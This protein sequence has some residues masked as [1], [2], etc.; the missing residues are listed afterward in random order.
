MGSPHPPLVVA[1]T[2]Q[3]GG[4]VAT[5]RAIDRDPSGFVPD[6]TPESDLLPSAFRRT[7]HACRYNG[8]TQI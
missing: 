7:I 4:H 5:L 1:A 2:A 8:I 3:G 6:L